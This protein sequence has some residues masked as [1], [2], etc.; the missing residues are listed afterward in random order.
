MSAS[1]ASPADSTTQVVERNISG[2]LR[3]DAWFRRVM[4]FGGLLVIIAISLIFFYLASVV[5]PMF[6]PAQLGE[7]RS[8]KSAAVQPGQVTGLRLDELR[9]VMAQ[10]GSDGTIR[11]FSYA[12]GAPLGEQRIALPE[13]VKVTSFGSGE[14]AYRFNAYGLSDGR[15]VVFRQIFEVTFPNDRRVVT[16]KL[17][18][19]F[20]EAPLVLDEQGAPIVR[21]SM[22]AEGEQLAAAA[23]TAD[24]RVVFAALE[25]SKNLI[26]GAVT[27][28][29]SGAV[30]PAVEGSVQDVF[31]EVKR[32]E[33]LVV[34]GGRFIS[35]FNVEN[36]RQPVLMSRF[37]PLRAGERITAAAVLSGGYSIVVGSD[38]G[39]LVQWFGVR[40]A[41]NVPVMTSIRDFPRMPAAVTTLTAEH[42]RKGFAAGDE[43]GNVG[44]YYATSRKLVA[45]KRFSEQPIELIEIAPRANGIVVTDRSGQVWLADLKND[46]P[47]VSFS[48]LWQKVWYEGYEKPEYLWQSSAATSDFEAKFS[49]AP[50]TF[51]T[52]KAAF[53]A[54]L[55]SIPLAILGAIYAAY[56]MSAKLR[57]VVKPTIEIMEAL[58]TVI[59]GFL[60]GL[61]LAPLADNNLP[62]VLLCFVVIPL[63]IILAAYIWH[64]LPSGLTLRVAP[65]WEAALLLP[66]VILA[67]WFCFQIGHPIEVALFNGD[68][69]NWL[70]NELGITYEQRNSLVVGIAMG[71]AVTPTIFSIAE[72]AIFQVPRH[73]TSG[74]LALGATPWQ[75][76]TRVVLLTASPGIFS[77]VMIGLGRAVGE[78]MIVL[79][80]TGNT[81]VMDFGIFTGFRTL[82][83][84]IGVEMPEAAVGSTHYRLLFL[85]ALVLFAF[86]FAVNTAA[87][88]VRHRLREK[89]SSI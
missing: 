29:R 8:M 41:E 71:F 62:A 84:N 69:P 4:T 51:G 58:P 24:G 33:L 73:L 64:R 83:A 47:E 86:T 85:S 72:D 16:P 19:P 7:V 18:F 48:S 57:T 88:L 15:I 6:L 34:H 43:R 10:Y 77:A 32:R 61:W 63:F 9:E 55:V 82:S 13:G 70:S 52:L 81:A 14:A 31:L 17:E 3:R 1:A 59:L 36:R 56:F 75:T 44:I 23:L 80:A 87:E 60:A 5:A 54:M 79:M 45:D 22:Q 53:Y 50:L 65:G 12:N 67:M 37:E 46:Y 38:Q 66:V 68:M 42:F 78:T 20:G 30:L 74:S 27:L 35:Q 2:R 26:T 40:S 39:S 11:F 49:L 28:E 25:G 89:Y 21:L 76:L